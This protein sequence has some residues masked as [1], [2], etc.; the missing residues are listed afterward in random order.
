MNCRVR[1]DEHRKDLHFERKKE[2]N[3]SM[4][5]VPVGREGSKVR[6][7]GRIARVFAFDGLELMSLVDHSLV[8]SIF[9][10][11]SSCHLV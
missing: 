9:E 2:T 11:E 6:R 7:E 1:S 3:Q 10:S 4:S 5:Q 8:G